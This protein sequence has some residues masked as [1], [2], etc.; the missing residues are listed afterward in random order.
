[1][2]D[3]VEDAVDGTTGDDEEAME[4][5][6]EAMADVEDAMEDEEAME[7]SGDA[8]EDEEEAMEDDSADT[9]VQADSSEL[10]DIH[11]TNSILGIEEA[12]D[13]GLVFGRFTFDELPL[14]VGCIER[15]STEQG[16]VFDLVIVDGDVLVD[17]N[18]NPV[19]MVLIYLPED[20]LTVEGRALV[21]ILDP[22]DCQPLG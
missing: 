18:N 9:S 13:L 12:I 16:P 15:F 10:S 21:E 19:S 4:S 17:S 8:M 7:D 14:D 2:T 5:D 3:A 6:E 22:V 1:M 11:V 20:P